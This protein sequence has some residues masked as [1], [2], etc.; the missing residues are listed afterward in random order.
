VELVGDNLPLYLP[1]DQIK[2]DQKDLFPRNQDSN[3]GW[4]ICAKDIILANR[5]SDL[6]ASA[7]T[8]VAADLT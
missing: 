7:W 3:M 1:A 4:K 8:V 5:W 6:N 2:L